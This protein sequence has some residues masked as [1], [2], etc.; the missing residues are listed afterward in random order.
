[1]SA[2]SIAADVGARRTSAREIVT[3]AL[4][5]VRASATLNAFTSTL[6]ERALA[7]ATSIDAQVAAG[8]DPGPLAGVPF[9]AKNL[10]DVAGSVTR[11]G[12]TVTARDPPAARDA[13]AIAALER[14]GAILIGLTNMDEFAY[15]F[16]TEN[17]HDGTTRNP[18]DRARIAGGSSGGSA[19]AVAAGIVPLSLGSDT[20]GSIRV[21]AALCGIFGVRPTF[22]TLSRA[23][24]FPFVNSL[25][26]IGP[27]ARNA[28]DLRAAYAALADTT[29]VRA[30]DAT[31]LRVARLGGYFDT[32]LTP[33]AREAV[34]SVAQALGGGATVVF[35]EAERA[36]KAAFVITAA[37]AGQLHLRRLREHASAYD[38]A[39]RDRLL[40]GALVPA[41]WYVLAQRFRTH[42]RSALREIFVSYDVLLAPATPYPA[43]LV[44]QTTI[45]LDGVTSDIRSNAGAFT[46]PI[47]F[48]G[49]PVLTVPVVRAGRLPVGVQLIGPPGSEATLFAL[50]QTLEESGAVGAGNVPVAG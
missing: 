31:G 9:A 16:T 35:E 3:A 36:R 37:E 6:D 48:A 46:Q 5:A 14:A 7:R 47:S 25:D 30:V 23:G 34:D 1:M 11:A 32:A 45:A 43:T 26:A 17:A 20:N 33:E 40:A 24:A 22:G 13:D 29:A 41:G 12:A 21:P 2:S 50:A 27:F 49:V 38:P 42:V 39:V 8:T 15:G 19:S 28:A 4:Q 10:F 18:H 44:G